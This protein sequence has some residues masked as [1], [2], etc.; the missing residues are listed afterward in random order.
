M[1][2]NC[3]V[4]VSG[5]HLRPGGISLIIDWSSASQAIHGMKRSFLLD[6]DQNANQLARRG[7]LEQYWCLEYRLPMN[8]Q[9]LS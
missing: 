7:F 9:V 1:P 4:N 6:Y 3:L 8:C 2:R 5:N